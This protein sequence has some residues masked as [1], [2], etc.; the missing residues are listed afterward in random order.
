[1]VLRRKSVHRRLFSEECKIYFTLSIL[2]SQQLNVCSEISA[3]VND[4][5]CFLLC[6]VRGKD[7]R[8]SDGLA[9]S[10]S[11]DSNQPPSENLYTD[12]PGTRLEP[13]FIET[14][15]KN[16]QDRT[17]LL[18]LEQDLTDYVYSGRCVLFPR[19]VKTQCCRYERLEST[20][21]VWSYIRFC[22]IIQGSQHSTSQMA[23]IRLHICCCQ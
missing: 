11:L 3:K 7:S 2:N 1:L 22:W 23:R 20:V 5:K 8:R 14:L 18:R 15:G 21:V 16:S 6:Q 17:F 12:V 10:M 4:E 13:F 9:R 19:L